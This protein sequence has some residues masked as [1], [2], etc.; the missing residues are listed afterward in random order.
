MHLQL[1]SLV[2]CASISSSFQIAVFIEI[3]VSY[4]PKYIDYKS[5][6]MKISR[7]PSIERSFFKEREMS[8]GFS[9]QYVHTL[10]TEANLY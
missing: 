3:L 5:D 8:E 4:F 7:I 1:L 2:G 10:I 6:N 9:W